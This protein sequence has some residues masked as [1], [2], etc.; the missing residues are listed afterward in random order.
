MSGCAYAVFSF[1]YVQYKK[2]KTGR[3]VLSPVEFSRI[4][5]AF[6]AVIRGTSGS[7]FYWLLPG[8]ENTA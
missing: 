5:S 7:K 3:V 6:K 2:I 8:K 4:P 1:I